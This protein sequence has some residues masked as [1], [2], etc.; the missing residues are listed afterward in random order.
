MKYNDF[1]RMRRIGAVLV[2]AL[3]AVGGFLAC[4]RSQ[5]VDPIPPAPQPNN[6]TQPI[7]TPPDT[8]NNKPPVITPPTT[9]NTAN[10]NSNDPL[11]LMDVHKEILRLQQQ[12]LTVEGAKNTGEGLQWRVKDNGITVEFRSDTN[13]GSTTWNRAKVD[14]NGNK[15]YD[16]RWDFKGNTITRRVSPNDDE[17]YTD[18]YVKSGDAWQKK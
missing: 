3:L 7:L 11:V 1:M 13:K 16:E 14:Y 10:T 12:P 4:N 9:T 6:N 17:N 5:K 8:N 18:S 2:M 15:K